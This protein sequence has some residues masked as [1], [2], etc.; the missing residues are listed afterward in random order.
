[1]YPIQEAIE[2][3]IAANARRND[4]RTALAEATIRA[5]ADA[6]DVLACEGH[7]TTLKRAR[8]TAIAAA[9]PTAA[10]AVDAELLR[11]SVVGEIAATRSVSS[12]AKHAEA[13]AALRA[14]EAAVA[15]A[16]RA[17][18]D[19]EMVELA[20]QF[21]AQF[22]HAI[23]TGEQLRELSTLDH[24]PIPLGARS[25]LP[26]AVTRALERL[27]KRNPLDTPI[28]QLRGAAVHSDRWSKRLA[29][30]T[31]AESAEPTA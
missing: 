23:E 20:R 30:L 9:R 3:R 1:M 19:S 10:I 31:A 18:I 29:Q 27:P 12:A 24:K 26:A 21:E 11:A 2:L 28:D 14:A 22:D 15:A 13:V 25:T 6:A 17:Q 8:A 16:A 5:D 4:A 7:M